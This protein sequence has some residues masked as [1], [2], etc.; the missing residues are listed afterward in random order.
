MAVVKAVL[1]FGSK[2]WVMTPRLEK[3]LKGFRHQV[4]RWMSVMDS[5]L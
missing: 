1:L 4:A 5:K 3:A 2:K